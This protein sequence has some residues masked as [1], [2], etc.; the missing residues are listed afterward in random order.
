MTKPSKQRATST[1]REQLRAQ[2][3]AEAQK[4]Q[5]TM[6][7][8]YVV[9]A[10]V[11]V[12]LVAIVSVVVVNDRNAKR[13]AADKQAASQF[14]PPSATAARNGYLWNPG[15]APESAP[16]LTIYED[17]QCPACKSAEDYFGETVASLATSGKIR[18]E[19]RILTFLDVNLRN[20]ASERSARAAACADTVGKF[21]EYH[22]TVYAGQ[23]ASEGAG[24]SEQQLRVDF[25][26]L[27]GITGGDLTKFQACYDTGATAKW[28]SESYKSGTEGWAGSTPQYSV[29][30]NNPKVKGTDGQETDWWRVL[31][32]TEESWLKAIEQHG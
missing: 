11:L 16:T 19:Y 18:V 3:L 28:V 5:R 32:P 24:Y 21:K 6:R 7:I 29:N 22:D 26:T 31:E 23:P 17:F 10:L 2:Q 27:A 30:G 12:A 20:D 1:R 4:K 8:I 13:A 25:P 14:D 9:S 15:N